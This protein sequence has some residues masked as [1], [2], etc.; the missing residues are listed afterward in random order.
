MP[1]PAPSAPAPARIVT[2]RTGLSAVPSAA[3]AARSSQA[4]NAVDDDVA[5]RDDERSRVRQQP[6]GELDDAERH[7]DREDP[8]HDGAPLA[9]RATRRVG[10]SGRDG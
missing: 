7:R 2:S 8:G 4:G 5:A 10:G 6:G 9:R 3:I 1:I